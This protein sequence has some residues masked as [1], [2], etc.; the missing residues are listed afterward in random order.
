MECKTGKGSSNIAVCFY[1]FVLV[2]SIRRILSVNKVAWL[3]HLK[4][5]HIAKSRIPVQFFVHFNFT[6]GNLSSYNY[7]DT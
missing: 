5:S 3:M 1:I 2:F 6:C 7:V 4:L